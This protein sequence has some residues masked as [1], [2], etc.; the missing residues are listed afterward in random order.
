MPTGTGSLAWMR[1]TQLPAGAISQDDLDLL[2][3]TDDPDEAIAIITAFALGERDPD[4]AGLGAL[5][6]RHLD[7]ARA[8]IRTG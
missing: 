6:Q 3:V 4:E 8:T 2:R 7:H 1:D 5:G